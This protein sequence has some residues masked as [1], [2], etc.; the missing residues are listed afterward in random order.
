MVFWLA[1]LQGKRKSSARWSS[2][3]VDH[4][5]VGLGNGVK[6]FLELESYSVDLNGHYWNSFCE[7]PYQW[8]DLSVA[9]GSQVFKP[10]ACRLSSNG[11]S[12]DR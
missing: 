4:L 11:R 3:I 2:F 8:I 6:R 9:F 7:V 1:E 5:L 10:T 12:S